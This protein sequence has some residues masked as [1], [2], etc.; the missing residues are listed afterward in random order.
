MGRT[1]VCWDNAQAET[2]FASF[3]TECIYRTVLASHD[4]A[5]RVTGRWIE[6]T[7]NQRRRHSAL[8]YQ[9]PN[10]RYYK[11]TTAARAA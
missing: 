8:D 9:T 11:L 2:F 10:Q 1:G 5:R 7:Y 3:K 4:Q 6:T